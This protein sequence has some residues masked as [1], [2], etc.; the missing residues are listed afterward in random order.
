M[1]INFF[2][3]SFGRSEFKDIWVSIVLKGNTQSRCGTKK[4]KITIESSGKD[5]RV[6]DS[7]GHEEIRCQGQLTE[8]CQAGT[9]YISVFYLLLYLNRTL[10]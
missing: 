2:S 4:K 7:K 5:K 10:I 8:L 9:E 6:I 1:T 3:T